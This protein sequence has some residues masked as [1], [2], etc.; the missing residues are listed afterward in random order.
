MPSAVSTGISA[1]ALAV[2]LLL[3]GDEA[4]VQAGVVQ[5]VQDA[6]H[7][8]VAGQVP[9]LRRLAPLLPQVPQHAVEDARGG[10]P[11]SPPSGTGDTAPPGSCRRST[12]SPRRWPGTASPRRRAGR[13]GRTAPRP[14]RAGSDTAHSGPSAR[15]PVR[16][17][18][19][20][21]AAMRAS[22]FPCYKVKGLVQP[23]GGRVPLLLQQQGQGLGDAR[24]PGPGRRRR[25]GPPGPAPPSSA[26]TPAPACPAL[27]PARPPPLRRGPGGRTGTA[28]SARGVSSAG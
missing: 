18:S 12:A 3:G 16:W 23:P 2:E 26:E 17:P 25:T 27:P 4:P 14:D 6:L 24:S 5:L 1:A 11:G 22:S 7:R 8:D 9:Q 15:S 19:G 20:P 13:P 10:R 28:A 21:C